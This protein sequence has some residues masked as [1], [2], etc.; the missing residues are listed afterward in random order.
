[1]QCLACGAENLEQA[2]FCSVCGESLPKEERK[3]LSPAPRVPTKVRRWAYIGA[4]IFAGVAFIFYL[5]VSFKIR[6][7]ESHFNRGIELS[8]KSN[9]QQAI[10]EF[11]K[12]LHLRPQDPRI[13]F[14]LG[15]TY[16][17]MGNYEDALLAF[18]KVVVFEPFDP[19]A[20]YNLGI[21][22]A[23]KGL[24]DKAIAEFGLYLKFSPKAK[25]VPIVKEAI[26]K[27]EDKLA[28]ES[29]RNQGVQMD[30]EEKTKSSKDRM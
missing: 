1:M 6:A 2:R 13:Q 15:I 20:H 5:F 8:N 22:Y 12:A 4:G 27:L 16:L 7:F 19:E 23:R 29:I 26:R 9:Y 18:Q 11:R 21:L 25:D 14:N 24:Y 28:Q 3:E 30:E 17:R 10:G